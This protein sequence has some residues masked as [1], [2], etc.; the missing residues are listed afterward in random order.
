MP[1]AGL[2]LAQV[3]DILIIAG[4]DEATLPFRPTNATFLVDSIDEYYRF[5]RSNGATI[6]RPPQQV[7]T[8]I[9]MNVRHPDGLIV[10]YVEH[11]GQAGVTGPG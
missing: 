3:G 8:G 7:P 5:L 6:I 11:T 2:E 9:N 1:A 4:P 10:E